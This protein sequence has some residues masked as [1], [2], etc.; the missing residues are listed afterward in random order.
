MRLKRSEQTVA[1]EGAV[2]AESSHSV[3]LDP[4]LDSLSMEWDPFACVHLILA[5]L[6]HESHAPDEV[7]DTVAPWRHISGRDN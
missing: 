1:A 5:G 3:S 7:V 4:S 6:S 2:E